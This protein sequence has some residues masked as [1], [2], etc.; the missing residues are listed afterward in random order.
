[1][2][3]VSSLSRTGIKERPWESRDW[4]IIVRGEKSSAGNG[5]L[6]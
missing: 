3:N 1:L 2:A 4:S 6:R 5:G